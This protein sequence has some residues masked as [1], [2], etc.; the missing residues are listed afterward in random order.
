M[1]ALQSGLVDCMHAMDIER[2]Q[3]M[4]E[5]SRFKLTSATGAVHNTLRVRLC[6][7]SLIDTS[8]AR[9]ISIC[10]RAA[11]SEMGPGTRRRGAQIWQGVI[12]TK[13]HPIQHLNS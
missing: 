6:A 11:E 5:G 8:W 4:F 3:F 9:A 7:L 1:T 2:M 12:G 13:M 10:V